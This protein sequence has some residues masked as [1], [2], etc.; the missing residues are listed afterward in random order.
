MN[1]KLDIG[2]GQTLKYDFHKCQADLNQHYKNLRDTE[3]FANPLE[4]EFEKWG[5]LGNEYLKRNN[6]RLP[7][8]K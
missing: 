2:A 6:F 1:L 3:G 4:F 5:W 8:W 7:S